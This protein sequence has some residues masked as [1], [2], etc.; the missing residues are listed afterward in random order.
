VISCNSLRRLCALAPLFFAATLAHAEWTPKQ[1]VTIIVPY[2]AG[3][4]GDIGVRL[5]APVLSEE[6]GQPVV[7]QNRG[8]AG[9]AIGTELGAKAPADG[10]TLTLG[11]DVAMTI[12]PHL[13]KLKYDAQKDFEAVGL[14]A[15]VPSVVVVS[16]KLD[17]KSMAELVQLSRKKPLSFGTNG[18]GTNNHLTGELLRREA[19]LDFLHV[20]FVA[21]PHVITGVLAGDIDFAVSSVGTVLPHIRSGKL[22][23]L[24]LTSAS[25]LDAL[26]GVPTLKEAGYDVDVNIWLGLFAPAKTPKDA[27]ARISSALRKALASAEVKARFRDLGYVPGEGT[28]D[29]LG[30]FVGRDSARW[31]K[32]IVEEN[33]RE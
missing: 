13:R 1:P 16:P 30:K 14:L 22:K 3:G 27:I 17:V 15:T 23:A 26:P 25:R 19:K 6:L 11:S 24:A 28:P 31:A 9:G 4:A 18:I 29:G 12:L 2:A 7:I 32:V 8:G 5:L 21:Q 20:P 33:I 10:Y